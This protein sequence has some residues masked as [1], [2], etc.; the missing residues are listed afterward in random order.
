MGDP[1][2]NHTYELEAAIAARRLVEHIERLALTVFSAEEL[3]AVPPETRKVLDMLFKRRMRDAGADLTHPDC[4][5]V[6]QQFDHYTNTRVSSP[7]AL[8]VATQ[9]R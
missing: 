8:R 3:A 6:R 7:L 5:A 2:G 4:L 9:L 1:F